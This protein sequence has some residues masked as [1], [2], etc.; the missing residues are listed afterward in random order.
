VRKLLTDLC[1]YGLREHRRHGD[2]GSALLD[3]VEAERARLKPIIMAYAPRDRWNC[4]ETGLY[5][6]ALPNR[7]LSTVKMSGKKA[8]KDCIT[9]MFACNADGSEKAQIHFIGRAKTPVVFRARSQAQCG[10]EWD[11]NKTAWMN[12]AIFEK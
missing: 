3:T 4:D 7:G 11:H 6:D 12:S 1:S 2:A 5:K 9:L 8:L 10:F